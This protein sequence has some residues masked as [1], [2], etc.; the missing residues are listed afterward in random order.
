M[1]RLYMSVNEKQYAYLILVSY[2]LI[3]LDTGEP[4]NGPH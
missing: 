1:F 4:I 2:S 3:S